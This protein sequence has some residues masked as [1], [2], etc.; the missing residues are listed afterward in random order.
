MRVNPQFHTVRRFEGCRV[1]AIAV[2]ILAA[3]PFANA[4]DGGVWENLARMNIARQEIDAARVGDFIYVT[5]GLIADPGPD[6]TDTG[7][8]Y[9]IVNDAWSMIAP[10]PGSI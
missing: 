2:V 1:A 3:A 9:D 6:T 4:D 5:G 7:E 8:V 10:M